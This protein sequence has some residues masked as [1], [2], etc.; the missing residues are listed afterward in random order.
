MIFGVQVHGIPTRRKMPHMTT[1]V[2]L[3]VTQVGYIPPNFSGDFDQELN[4]PK[5]MIFGV[6][7]H[8]TLKWRK[9][10]FMTTFV[11]PSVTQSIPPKSSGAF[12]H[13]RVYIE[14]LILVYRFMGH[15]QEVK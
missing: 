8:E 4:L 2:G 10:T 15:P 12:N 14:Q 3:S 13:D 6:N 9:M 7:V 11:H 5:T 1:S